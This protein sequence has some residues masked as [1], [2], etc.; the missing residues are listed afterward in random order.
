MYSKDSQSRFGKLV[1]KGRGNFHHSSP[2]DCVQRIKTPSKPD[3]ETD[4]VVGMTPMEHSS[5]S[6]ACNT[7]VIEAASRKQ[8]IQICHRP[9]A[10]TATDD[11]NCWRD[12]VGH[13][14]RGIFDARVNKEDKNEET[15]S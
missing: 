11:N 12:G 10:A 7:A 8:L 3:Q 5:V 4:Y 2:Y 14:E 13:H 9:R 15:E 1:Q 6:K